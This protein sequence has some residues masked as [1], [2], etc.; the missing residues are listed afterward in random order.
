MNQLFYHFENVPIV[1]EQLWLGLDFIER[2]LM[3]FKQIR[4][5][6]TSFFI[7]T[8]VTEFYKVVY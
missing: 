8:Y 3:V 2:S 6:I 1:L 7:T 4:E 5:D